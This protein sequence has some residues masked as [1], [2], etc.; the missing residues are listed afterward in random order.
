MY[1][2]NAFIQSYVQI[3]HLESAAANQ[4]SPVQ[5]SHEFCVFKDGYSKISYQCVLLGT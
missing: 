2:V 1:L 3:E 5:R 4:H